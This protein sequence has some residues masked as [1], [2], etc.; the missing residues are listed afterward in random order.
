MVG[1]GSVVGCAILGGLVGLRGHICRG[2]RGGKEQG[3]GREDP[4]DC[5]E[6]ER[7]GGRK[8]K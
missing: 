4:P 7:Q 6:Q 2:G 8:V 3:C 5:S 1:A